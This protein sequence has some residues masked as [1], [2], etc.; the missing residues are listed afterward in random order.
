MID[1][2]Q[3]GGIK[4]QIAEIIEQVWIK[5]LDFKSCE[6]TLT[7]D[8]ESEG[9]W[10][11]QMWAGTGESDGSVFRKTRPRIDMDKSKEFYQSYHTVKEFM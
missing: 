9:L 6:Y 8:S 11:A 1:E 3:T 2:R 5:M 4:K 10:C 7:H